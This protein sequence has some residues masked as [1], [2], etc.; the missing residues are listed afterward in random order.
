LRLF[1]DIAAPGRKYVQKKA[2]VRKFSYHKCITIYKETT[3]ERIFA[4]GKAVLG[5]NW[6]KF[7]IL[8]AAACFA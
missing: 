6:R 8:S 2:L 1:A 3:S 7:T 4:R 5:L